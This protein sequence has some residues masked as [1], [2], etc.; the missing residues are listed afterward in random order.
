MPNLYTNCEI[1]LF[2][3]PVFG[4]GLWEQRNEITEFLK[5]N[6]K[7]SGQAISVWLEDENF[8]EDDEKERGG[9][10]AVWNIHVFRES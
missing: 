3:C 10:P 6:W 7:R 5:R 9:K 8:V 2:F 4:Y 1:C